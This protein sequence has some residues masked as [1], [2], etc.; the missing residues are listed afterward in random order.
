[1]SVRAKQLVAIARATYQAML[2]N[3]VKTMYLHVPLEDVDDEFSFRPLND[4]P[5]VQDSNILDVKRRG[6]VEQI[7][8]L[9]ISITT[10]QSKPTEEETKTTAETNVSS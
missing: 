9:V 8:D 1:M 10:D 6:R 4:L 7:T 2:D 3:E 5:F